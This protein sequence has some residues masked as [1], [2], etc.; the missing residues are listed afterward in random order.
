MSNIIVSLTTTAAQ[1]GAGIKRIPFWVVTTALIGIGQ[2]TPDT[3]V[4]VVKVELS[5]F[6]G[7]PEL[8]VV[9]VVVPDFT[10]F[11]SVSC[12]AKA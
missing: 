5:I 10:Q 1:S 11:N 3:N 4:L 9:S 6:L 8:V 12:I 2:S 7:V